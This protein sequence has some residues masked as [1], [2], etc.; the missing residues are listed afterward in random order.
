MILHEIF[1]SVIVISLKFLKKQESWGIFHSG[2]GNVVFLK[3]QGTEKL[4]S[5]SIVRRNGEEHL[6]IFT[7]RVYP[8]YPV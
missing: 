1:Q 5:G 7:S 3:L 4:F 2:N 8:S 6:Q